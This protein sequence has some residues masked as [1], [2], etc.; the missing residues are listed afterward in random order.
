MGVEVSRVKSKYTIK[1]EGSERPG[2]SA[3]Y[4]S[5]FAGLNSSC[6]Y[7]S[8]ALTL[9]ESFLLSMKK[10]PNKNFLG[11][12]ENIQ[13]ELGPYKWQ[14]YSEISKLSHQ[15]GYALDYL[16][17][18]DPDLDGNRF[19]CIYSKNCIEWTIIDLACISQSITTLPIYDVQQKESI[20]LIIEQTKAK[21][22]FCPENLASEIF[23]MKKN[24][25]IPSIKFVAQFEEV[26]IK[27]KEESLSVGVQIY[28][29][30]ELFQMC[31]EGKLNPPKPETWFTICY[32]SGTTGI[33][34]GA[35]ITHKNVISMIN[36]SKKSDFVWI[37]EEMYLSYLPLAHIMERTVI[38][39]IIEVGGSI[40]FY[41]GDLLK[42]RDDIISLKP[43]MFVSVPR[44]FNR[45]YA[46]LNQ[47]ITKSPG[48]LGAL[49]RK[50]LRQKLRAFEENGFITHAI[51]DKLIFNNF[52]NFLG[53]KIRAFGSGSAPLSKDV[54]NFFKVVFS[55]PFVEGYGQ[56]ES[57]GGCFFTNKNE[58]VPEIIGGP[59]A[60]IEFKL[61][62]VP[63][64]DYF[65]SDKNENLLPTPRGEI[66]I[67][68]EN[69]TLGYYKALDITKETIDE[70]GWLHTGDIGMILPYNG[71]VKIIDRKKNIFKLSQGEYV[72]C[73]KLENVYMKCPFVMQI[74]I[75]GDSFQSYLVAVVVP[76]EAYVR[77]F[78]VSPN[79]YQS[80]VPLQEI[81]Q[82]KHFKDFM[83]EEFRSLA[84][85]KKLFGFEHIKNLYIEP[86]PWTSNDLLTPTQKLIR[87]KARIHYKSIIDA[88]Y[89]EH[90]KY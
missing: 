55:C 85:D 70:D 68:G 86:K 11:V 58:K 87:H 81:C 17:I 6:D 1:V 71:A 25:L 26:N 35:I 3:I 34:K 90:G 23:S 66:C 79:A 36:S 49:I 5:P 80:E 33:P 52:K 82:D 60:N 30:R 18:T 67:K 22:I 41:S 46:L 78:W 10:R 14:T 76:D 73:E 44:L 57:C 47:S 21:I 83:I 62:D 61:Q 37:E 13:G 27:A 15:L 2:C 38:H 7:Q 29:M 59:A 8:Q 43:T 63:E 64:M 77:K 88:L 53:G 39:L 16:K 42:L 54:T 40:G 48:P 20:D 12:R 24:G 89:N 9:Y 84:K 51:W 31:P 69:V 19:A 72:A 4:R 28:S 65:S 45:F 75:Y 50:A 74:F 56:T 32:T